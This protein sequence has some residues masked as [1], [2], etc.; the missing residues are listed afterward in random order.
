VKKTGSS[1]KTAVGAACLSCLIAAAAGTGTLSAYAWEQYRGDSTNNGVTDSPLPTSADEAVLYW[2]EKIGVDAWGSDGPSPLTLSGDT[3]YF[4]AADK[5]CAMDKDTGEVLAAGDMAGSPAYGIIPPLYADGVIF[6]GLNNGTVQA[7][8]AETLE[9]L[10]IYKDSLGGQ[11]I[12]P[13][14]YSD[15]CIYTGFWRS[16]TADANFVCI[17]VKDEDTSAGD[18]EKSAKWSYTS[19]GGFYWTGAYAEGSFAVV[20]TDDGDTGSTSESAKLV[21][22]DK[23]TGEQLDIIEGIK[24]DIRSSIAYDAETDRYYFTS[25]GGLF[26]SVKIDENGSFSDLKTLD[27]GAPTSCTPVISGGRAYVGINGTGWNRYNG[28]AIAVIDLESNSVAYTAE[29]AGAPQTSGLLCSKDGYNYV[30][31]VENTSP[32]IIRYVKDKQGVTEVIDPSEEEGHICAPALFTPVGAQANYGM[33]NP[34]CDDDGTIYFKND[35]SYIMAVGPAVESLRTEGKTLFREGDPLDSSAFRV[36]AK[37]ANGVEKD[38]TDLVEVSSDTVSADDIMYTVTYDYALYSDGADGAGTAVKPVSADVE[39]TVLKAEE[40]DSVYNVI[41]LIDAIGTVTAD[42]ESAVSAAENAYEELDASLRQYVGN[43]DKLTDARKTLD[44]LLSDSS[45]DPNA[46]SSESSSETGDQSSASSSESSSGT[47]DQS[48][49]SSSKSSSS[50]KGNSASSTA[51][52]AT[53][54]AAGGMLISA[55]ALAGCLVIRKRK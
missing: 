34:V 38:V 5:I 36:Y 18:E 17:D 40:Y 44:G 27:L 50:S 43:Y 2:A 35:S 21:S 8:D 31:F 16:E 13:L 12:A 14:I 25:K 42:S 26:C 45:E 47:G 22:F 19:K 37:L 4:T 39:I 41:S 46:S 53:G 20:G 29:T 10:W 9:S 54:A 24:G 28:S 51:N 1:K 11:T 23:E 6:A 7:F 52:P 49:S 3:L 55:A 48:A 33:Y 15:G 32:S 30:Y